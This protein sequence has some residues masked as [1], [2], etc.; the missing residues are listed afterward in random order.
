MCILQ[1]WKRKK[2]QDGRE[3]NRL[4][5]DLEAED[6]APA[7]SRALAS[8]LCPPPG[9]GR[10]PAFSMG[11]RAPV[12]WKPCGASVSSSARAGRGTS[13]GPPRARPAEGTVWCGPA[14]GHLPAGTDQA[15]ETPGP[16]SSSPCLTRTAGASA[17]VQQPLLS[18]GTWFLASMLQRCAVWHGWAVTS[19]RGKASGNRVPGPGRSEGRGRA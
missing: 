17:P 4:M 16:A 1:Q 5:G 18:P 3:E 14:R 9:S 13:G 8:C 6:S 15:E 10:D 11:V 12:L 2:T 19:G 7:G